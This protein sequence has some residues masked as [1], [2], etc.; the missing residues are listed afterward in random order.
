[1]AISGRKRNEVRG[2]SGNPTGRFTAERRQSGDCQQSEENM[3]RP[4]VFCLA[5]ALLLSTVHRAPAPIS[6]ESPTPTPEQSAKPKPKRTVKPK[7]S[8]SS[9]SSTKRQTPTSTPKNRNPFDGTWR[10]FLN[11]V[12]W[13][14]VINGTGTTLTEKSAEYGTFTPSV[15][16]DGASMR[17]TVNGCS[18]IFTPSPDGKTALWTATCPGFLGI[19]AGSWSTICRKTSPN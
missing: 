16:C 9:E 19:G 14:V 18:N 3:K 13:T 12:D 11:N 6:E 8:E 4:L 2:R 5:T 10:G 1:M 17:Y 15:T 7:A